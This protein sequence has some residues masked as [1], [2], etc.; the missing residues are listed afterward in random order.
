MNRMNLVKRLFGINSIKNFFKIICLKLKVD[1]INI[2]FHVKLDQ[3][4]I[5]REFTT[6]SPYVFLSN[7]NMMAYAKV[8]TNAYLKNVTMG[9]YSAIGEHTVFSDSQIGAY[10]Y[11][12]SNCVMYNAEIGKFCSIAANVKI[13]LGKHPVDFISTSPVF[14]SL[15]KQC[16]KSFTDR[17]LFKEGEDT[18]IGNDVWIGTNV[19]ILDGI[20]IGDGSIIGAGSVVTKDVE[21][22]TIVAGIPAKLIKKRFSE[23]VVG[24]LQSLK[25]WN[26]EEEKLIRNLALFQH[27]EFDLDN[28]V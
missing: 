1:H 16:G 9:A 21:P 15:N 3:D 7:V 25:W 23:E 14:Y 5:L 2:S 20:K 6:V 28:I 11:I 12:S 17:S 26:W 18:Y 8:A 10:S 19:I 27:H 13:G 24:K 4:N 22:Y